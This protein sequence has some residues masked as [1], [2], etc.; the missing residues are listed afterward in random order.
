MKKEIVFDFDAA[1]ALR[2]RKQVLKFYRGLCT[3]HTAGDIVNS[4]EVWRSV[5]NDYEAMVFINML[6]IGNREI[7]KATEM[8]VNGKPMYIKEGKQI[9]GRYT[10]SWQRVKAFVP[11]SSADF[12]CGF[13][14]VD[15]IIVGK[16]ETI[17]R[18][19]YKSLLGYIKKVGDVKNVPIEVFE[20]YARLLTGYMF[21]ECAIMPG[22]KATHHFESTLLFDLLVKM[23]QLLF[24]KPYGYVAFVEIDDGFW[25]EQALYMFDEV[26]TAIHV[27]DEPIKKRVGEIDMTEYINGA[28]QKFED[29]YRNRNEMLLKAEGVAKID[30]I[31]QNNMKQ[32]YA[33]VV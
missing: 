19:I 17:R 22:L 2:M 6:Y 31:I 8:M 28:E 30:N 4:R 25:K 24:Y 9:V 7:V 23:S 16:M 20:C 13:S 18:H 14:D 11:M 29:F 15:E 33:V 1:D 5:L 26:K 32:R 27:L 21:L 12:V 10:K 3:R